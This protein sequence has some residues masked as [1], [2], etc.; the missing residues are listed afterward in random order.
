M[1]KMLIS[2]L[3]AQE[4]YLKEFLKSQGEC[5]ESHETANNKYY[6]LYCPKCKHKSGIFQ[7]PNKDNYIFK[8]YGGCQFHTQRG[9]S[10][11]TTLHNLIKI[12]GG[13]NLFQR[14]MKEFYPREP[15]YGKNK[16]GMYRIKNRKLKIF[17]NLQMES[18]FLLNVYFLNWKMKN[19]EFV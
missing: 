1:D 4:K 9:S 18:Q 6:L 19:P 2:N 5:I 7:S 13:S 8:C 11:S 10:D 17:K 14:W 3:I 16:H 15:L 12:H